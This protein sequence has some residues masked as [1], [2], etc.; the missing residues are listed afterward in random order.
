MYASF[1]P[2]ASWYEQRFEFR[3]KVEC[4]NLTPASIYRAV[5]NGNILTWKGWTISCSRLQELTDSYGQFAWG[6]K[7]YAHCESG[8]EHEYEYPDRPV[9]QARLIYEH[10][11]GMRFQDDDGLGDDVPH[12]L[13]R[14]YSES[15]NWP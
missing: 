8:A 15:D 14:G 9:Y 1:G 10:V 5:D 12:E 7:V 13:E 4:E 3:R 6:R 11:T 2:L